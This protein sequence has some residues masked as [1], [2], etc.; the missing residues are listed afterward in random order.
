MVNNC[1]ADY[2]VPFSKKF[3]VTVLKPVTFDDY[4]FVLKEHMLFYKSWQLLRS[5]TLDRAIGVVCSYQHLFS[6]D[7]ISQNKHKTWLSSITVILS[8]IEFLVRL[9]ELYY[10]LTRKTTWLLRLNLPQSSKVLIQVI[11]VS[12]VRHFHLCE[13]T[14]H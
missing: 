11:F 1:P 8:H 12:R 13:S 10:L 2:V 9:C 3:N 4:I 7:K 5:K 6:V 14:L